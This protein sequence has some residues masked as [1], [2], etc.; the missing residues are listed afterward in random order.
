LSPSAGKPLTALRA[1][2]LARAA[3]I[4]VYALGGVDPR[5]AKR[6]LGRGFAGIAAVSGLAEN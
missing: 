3:A 4:P 1:G 2:R 6:L 5:T